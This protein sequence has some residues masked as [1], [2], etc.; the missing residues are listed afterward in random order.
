MAMRGRLALG[1]VRGAGPHLV[2]RLGR[3]A[4]VEATDGTRRRL[5]PGRHLGHAEHRLDPERLAQVLEQLLG[6]RVEKD[7][8]L[9]PAAVA[10]AGRLDLGLVDRARPQLEV[11]EDLVGDRELDRPGELEAVAPDQLGGRGHA[12]DE[13]VLLEAQ[14]AQ[15]AAG[16]DRGRRQPVVPCADDDGVVVRH[17]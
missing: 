16:H 9:V 12:A 1:L 8:R 6:V 4:H 5:G 3:L 14:H 11:L 17:R 10:D 13:V 2:E 15:P 7:E